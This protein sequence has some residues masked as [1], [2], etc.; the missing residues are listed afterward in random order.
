MLKQSLA[1]AVPLSKK[2]RA[3]NQLPSLAGQRKV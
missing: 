2:V 1:G 3:M